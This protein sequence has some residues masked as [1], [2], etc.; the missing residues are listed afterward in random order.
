MGK[1]DKQII[2]PAGEVSSTKRL[3][4]QGEEGGTHLF[5][6]FQQLLMGLSQSLCIKTQVQST[7][8]VQV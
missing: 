8:T 3:G 4:T 1:T 6:R 2:I 7:N 5:K